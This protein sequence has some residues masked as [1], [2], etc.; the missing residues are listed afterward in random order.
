MDLK[1]TIEMMMSEDFRE[2][3]KAEYFQLKN[4][5][6]G[7]TKML[8]KYRDGSLPFKPK[9]DYNMLSNQLQAMQLY[10][11]CLEERAEVEGIELYK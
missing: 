10:C 2:R 11:S 5:I 9:S 6:D 3:F 8:E 7:L 1:N 4:R